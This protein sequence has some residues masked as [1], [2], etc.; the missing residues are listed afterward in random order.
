MC[1]SVCVC[2]WVGM[3]V[4]VC[5]YVS[6]SNV[7]SDSSDAVTCITL[8]LSCEAG[9]PVCVCVCVCVCSRHLRNTATSHQTVSHGSG[10]SFSQTYKDMRGGKTEIDEQC[11]RCLSE[12]PFQSSNLLEWSPLKQVVLSNSI[13]LASQNSMRERE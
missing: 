7:D 9:Y 11:L 12:T 3:C 8:S 10:R 13:S 1:I 4:S 2:V 5:V 6:V